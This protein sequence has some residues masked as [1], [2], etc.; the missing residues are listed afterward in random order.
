V[1]SLAIAGF[2]ACF[3]QWV[4]LRQIEAKAPELAAQVGDFAGDVVGTLKQVS[5]DWANDSNGSAARADIT[6]VAPAS[7]ASSRSSRLGPATGS[8]CSWPL[9][10]T[11]S[12][13]WRAFRLWHGFERSHWSS[14]LQTNLDERLHR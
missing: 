6:R 7:A 10:L 1:L 2:F 14:G 3:C 12:S 5:T 8:G 11:D 13:M 4:L 9:L